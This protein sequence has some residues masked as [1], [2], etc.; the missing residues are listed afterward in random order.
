LPFPVFS[1]PLPLIRVF[2]RRF[3]PTIFAMDFSFLFLNWGDY[4]GRAAPCCFRL[5]LFLGE[6]NMRFTFAGGMCGSFP[7]SRGGLL[8]AA[9]ATAFLPP[10]PHLDRTEGEHS[11]ISF[12]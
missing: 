8:V 3:V 7:G 11:G 4:H 6:P 9:L 5:T 10:L 12:P 2:P 1:W